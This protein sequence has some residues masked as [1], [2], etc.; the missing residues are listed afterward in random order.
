[1]VALWVVAM[2]WTM[3]S[4]EAEA[5]VV[6]GAA[7]AES[8]ERLEQSLH[9][10]CRDDVSGVRHGECGVS[11]RGLGCDRDGAVVRVVAQGVVHEIGQQALDQV[12]VA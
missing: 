5:A 10:G 7:G 11:C 1:M 3:D 6:A 2:A 9:F 4:P 8:L 12:R